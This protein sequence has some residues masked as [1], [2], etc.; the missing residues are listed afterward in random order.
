MSLPA[1]LA[2]ASGVVDLVTNIF[3]IE[4]AKASIPYSSEALS[5]WSALNPDAPIP[6]KTEC[7]RLWDDVGVKRIFNGLLENADGVDRA[8]LRA[9]LRPESGA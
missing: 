2:S 9:L 1:F 5:A 4:G 8:R 7:Q 3:S 6:K